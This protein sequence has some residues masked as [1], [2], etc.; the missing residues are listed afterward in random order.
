MK[1]PIIIIV[2][3]ILVAAGIAFFYSTR[4]SGNMGNPPKNVAQTSTGQ[5]TGSM[6]GMPSEKPAGE[7]IKPTEETQKQEETPTVEIPLEKQQL[8]GVKTMAASVQPLQKIIRTVGKIEYDERK[9]TTVNAKVEGWIEKLYVNFTGTYVK[10]G[11]PLADIYSPELWA[12][13]QEFINVIRWAKKTGKR[14]TDRGKTADSSG[15]SQNLTVMLSRDAE[16]IIDAAR[17]RLKLW[18]ISD[19]QI[20]RIEESEKPVRTLTVYSP[21]S[22]YVLQRY[23]TQGMKVM[24]GEKLLDVSDLSTVWVIADIYQYE[25]PFIKVG[26]AARIQLSNFPGKELTSKIDFVGPTLDA[27]TRTVKVRFS[28]PN[29]GGQL[30]PQ[31]FT[32]VEMKV[33]LGQKLAVPDDAVIDTGLRKI[34]YV[35]KGDGYFE[36]RVVTTGLRAEKLIEILSGL[37]AGEKIASA[38]NFLIDS[39]A[40]L[41]GIE[42]P[43]ANRGMPNGKQVEDQQQ[44]PA[45]AHRH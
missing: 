18:D 42:A 8:I 29:P 26:D 27:Q 20:K 24:A 37:K 5:Q 33:N 40:K 25:L 21:A 32:D 23:A 16:S 1:K 31:M 7:P 35:D 9:L 3:L 30:K 14:D 11:E 34:V 28:I 12:T 22:G 38:A 45:P 41:K 44:S 43:N 4:R 13:Q 15:D 39:E 10:K 36:P 17:Q 2:C 6:P 19:E